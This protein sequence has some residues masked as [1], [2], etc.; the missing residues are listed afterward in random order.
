[1]TTLPPLYLI[2][3][4]AQGRVA[5]DAARLC[6]PGRQLGFVDDNPGRQG[7]VTDGILIY[8]ADK[9][10]APGQCR[11]HVCIGDNATRLH[12]AR[13]LV[14][15]GYTLETI[16]HPTAAVAGTAQPGAGCCILAQAVVQAG[17]LLGIACIVNSAAVVEHDAHL[18]AGSHIAGRAYVG[19]GCLL[20]EGACIGAGAVVLE[21]LTVGEYAR[22]GAAA[23]LTHDQPAHSLW[24]GIPA[25][26][27]S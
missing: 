6:W 20:Q 9:L 2:G 25:R 22:L 11:V 5:A 26:N 3:A 16:I 21:N 18:Q 7:E 1:M 8:A 27:Q 23:L 15:A 12:K 14:T 19:P 10:P 17:A 4:G 13:A 24:Y